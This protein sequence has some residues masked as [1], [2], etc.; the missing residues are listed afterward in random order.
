MKI[1]L[2]KKQYR[3]L[4]K[5][6]YLGTWLAN[7]HRTDDI[8]E[9]FEELEQYI[10]S[11]CKD[12]GMEN[13]FEYDESLKRFYLTDEFI[14]NSGIDKL[15]DEYNLDTFWEELI[16]MMADKD[17]LE[18]YGEKGLKEMDIEKLTEKKILLL[19]LY[20][21][22]FSENGIKNLRVIKGTKTIQ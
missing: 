4:V 13:D 11:F 2:S 20:E 14:E 19:D 7:A 8:I 22:E 5:L 9:E 1:N 17:L 10:F 3:T 21:K 6:I 18:T 16:H 12:F 15:I